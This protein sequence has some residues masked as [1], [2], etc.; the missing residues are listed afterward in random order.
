MKIVYPELAGSNEWIQTSNPV[1]EDIIK[2]FQPI[3]LEFSVNGYNEPWEGLGLCTGSPGALICDT[4]K[5]SKWWMCIGCQAWFPEIGY[6]P[7]PQDNEGGYKY[8]VTQVELY[9]SIPQT[10]QFYITGLIFTMIIITCNIYIT[11]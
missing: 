11:L 6:I 1:T 3:K 10:G 4:P 8:L 9:V 7:G 2:G 5:E